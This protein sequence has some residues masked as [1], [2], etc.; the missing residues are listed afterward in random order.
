VRLSESPSHGKPVLLYDIES[1]G[2]K[3]YLELAQELSAAP[4]A[5]SRASTV[6]GEGKLRRARRH[7]P[8]PR[9]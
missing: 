2:A 1:K 7:H 3:A 4:T 6:R 5:I 9:R 8:R